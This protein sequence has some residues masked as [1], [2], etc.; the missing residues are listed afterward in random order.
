MAVAVLLGFAVFFLLVKPLLFPDVKQRNVILIVADALQADHLGCYG[1]D[2][3]LTPVIDDLAS[4]GTLFTDCN[5]VVPSTLASFTSLF[6][7][8][9]TK[10]HG[11]SRNGFQPLDGL[12][13]L[14]GALSAGGYETA[15]F[16]SSYAIHSDFKTDRGFDHFDERMT[17]S[18]ILFDNKLIRS[19][20]DV[21]DAFMQWLAERE[22]DRPFFAMVHYFDP[23]FP[24][25][26]PKRFVRPP[27]TR[28]AGA[29][30]N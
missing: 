20:S 11:A 1:F 12:P 3:P 13:T 9:H 30:G 28:T 17:Q 24:Y 10:D 2:R 8:R 15:A 26:P 4:G 18:T 22:D 25:R 14:A 29:E 6:T 19:A 5:S 21:T 16:I 7:S 27:V 23:H